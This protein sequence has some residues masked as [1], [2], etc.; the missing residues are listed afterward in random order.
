MS[1]TDIN[2]KT[3]LSFVGTLDDSAGEQTA[4]G[5]FRQYLKE[6][7]LQIGQV[8]DYIEDCLRTSGDQYNR[9]LQDLECLTKPLLECLPIDE[10]AAQ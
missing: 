1:N 5:R 10:R 7:I 8:R 9:A 6:N 3:I 2:L 4:R